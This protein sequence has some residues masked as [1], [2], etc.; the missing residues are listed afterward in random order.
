MSPG[1]ERDPSC[2]MIPA[3]AAPSALHGALLQ[4]LEQVRQRTPSLCPPP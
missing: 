1:Y 3:E 4:A 2:I